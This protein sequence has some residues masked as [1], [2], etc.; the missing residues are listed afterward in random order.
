VTYIIWPEAPYLEISWSSILNQ[1]NIE[2][3]NWEYNLNYTKKNLI[4]IK[5]TKIKIKIQ[6][7]F[8]IW[9][10]GEIE[11]NNNFYKRAKK[12]I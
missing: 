5:R 4:S 8:Y 1:S 11:K 9:M 10:K 2:G 12:K 3:W 7:K 6:N